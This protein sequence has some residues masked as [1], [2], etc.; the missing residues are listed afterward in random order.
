MAWSYELSSKGR[1]DVDGCRASC[2]LEGL[3]VARALTAQFAG[4][5]GGGCS[6]MSH[7]PGLGFRI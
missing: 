3:G 6:T 1:G 7:L 4:S 5:C 2:V